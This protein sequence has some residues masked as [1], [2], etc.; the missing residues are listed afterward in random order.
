MQRH[1]K[2]YSNYNSIPNNNE[3]GEVIMIGES[4]MGW[5]EGP[6]IYGI[7]IILGWHFK[8]KPDT[9]IVGWLIYV[10]LNYFT[11]R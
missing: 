6:F 4:I 5:F 11:L 1:Q 10:V 2:G 7:G 9:L 8:G 3:I